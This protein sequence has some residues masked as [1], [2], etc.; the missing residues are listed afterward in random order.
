MNF[1]EFSSGWGGRKTIHQQMH[2]GLF[3][4]D[5]QDV[6]KALGTSAASGTDGSALVPDSID[7]VMKLLIR[8]PEM[9]APKLKRWYAY[10]AK[11]AI[12]K[13]IRVTRRGTARQASMAEGDLGPADA[14]TLERASDEVFS[15]GKTTAVTDRLAA[16][17]Q[18]LFGDVKAMNSML[19]F[20]DVMMI[21]ERNFWWGNN[22]RYS[23]QFNG[24]MNRKLTDSQ[25]YKDLTSNTSLGAVTGVA[26][27]RTYY[28]SGGL[29]DV[30]EIRSK[31]RLALPYNCAHTGL[32]LHPDDMDI[33]SRTQD[34]NQRILLNQ[35]GSSRI[36]AGQTVTQIANGF[37]QDG[38]TDLIWDPSLYD[39]GMESL[40]PDNPAVSTNFHPQAPSVPATAPTGVAGAGSYLKPGT[41]Y[42]GVQFNNEISNSPIKI[43][44]TGYA[45][46]NT[47]GKVTLTIAHPAG[48]KSIQIF[49]SSTSAAYTDMV[50]LTEVEP[51]SVTATST[52]YV[53]TG[54]IMP[55]R[56]N[57]MLMDERKTGIGYL[58]P[59]AMED[60]S[61]TDRTHKVSVGMDVALSSYDGMLAEFTWSGIGGACLDADR[62]A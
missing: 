23:T 16:S 53:D 8:D 59:P 17:A 57:A 1:A 58:I 50:F 12:Q 3:D 33:V 7:P 49:R 5:I 48:I 28:E 41:F 13:H 62:L 6:S 21:L 9:Q 30:D 36:A 35:G 37:S 38:V 51:A 45:A 26:G 42:Y 20:M 47:N 15:I 56:R 31:N 43:Q 25:H 19:L 46:D 11:S 29:L 22:S 60:L 39:E 55:G 40:V 44:S 61:R 24:F 52:T 32:Y 54:E 14:P 2:N 27:S 4:L 10:D 18:A 34:P